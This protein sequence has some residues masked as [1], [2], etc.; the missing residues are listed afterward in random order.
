MRLSREQACRSK[1]LDKNG[2]MAKEALALK[3]RAAAKKALVR[4]YARGFKN[5]NRLLVQIQIEENLRV[6]SQIPDWKGLKNQKDSYIMLKS[7][8]GTAVPVILHLNYDV[9]GPGWMT[10]RQLYFEIRQ[11]L[12]RTVHLLPKHSL[13]VAPH[14]PW[15]HHCTDRIPV[16]EDKALLA[17]GFFSDRKCSHLFGTSFMFYVYDHLDLN[18]HLT[19]ILM[20]ICD[21]LP[22]SSAKFLRRMLCQKLPEVLCQ[23]L[24]EDV[25]STMI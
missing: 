2:S 15:Y 19:T 25:L 24:P 23:K 6:V 17:N 9:G 8:F 22:Q 5:A 12:Q 21:Y 13:R 1:A 18:P 3:C 4:W 14:R 16:P 10:E 7:L 20:I 11:H